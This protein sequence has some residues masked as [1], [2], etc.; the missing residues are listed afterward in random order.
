MAYSILSGYIQLYDTE[1]MT[2]LLGE[3][4]LNLWYELRIQCFRLFSTLI[5]AFEVEEAGTQSNLNKVF[6]FFSLNFVTNGV[7]SVL[8]SS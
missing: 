7:I 5:T 8:I 3:E 4:R 1:G 6:A 2:D